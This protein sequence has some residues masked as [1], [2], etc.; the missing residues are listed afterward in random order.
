M[1]IS[2]M[3]I[4]ELETRLSEINKELDGEC[5]IAAL[6]AEVSA[7]EARKKEIAE[8]AKKA[9]ELRNQI[10][11]GEADIT[12]VKPVY[13]EERTMAEM[14][15]VEVRKSNEYRNAWLKNL[16][17]TRNGERLFGEM[18]EEERTAFTFLTSNTSA[19]VPTVIL[20][21]I[22][23][24]VASMAPMYDDAT[25]S[26]MTQGFAVP[27]LKS[28][29]Q[30]DAAVTDEAVANDDEQDTFDQLAIDGEEIKKH[31][32]M[33][34]KMKWQSIDAFEDWVVT[35]IAKRIAVAKEGAIISAL[36][37]VSTGI[38]AANVIA[39]TAGTTYSDANIRMILAKIK[40]MGVKVWYANSNTIYNGLAGIQDNNGRPLFL[41]NTTESD[42]AIAG[43]IYGG[44]VKEDDNLA[45]NVVYAGVPA[46]I[47]ANNFEELFI[48]QAIDPKTFESII[49]GYSLF[50][51]GLENPLAFVKVTFVIPEPEDEGGDGGVV[52]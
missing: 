34:R 33:S 49:G 23:E 41:A 47:L 21:R 15:F 8:E 7:I 43:R 18:N 22:V 39:A 51:A 29:A 3:N 42:P 12:D 17:V 11:N 52:V 35:H 5:D 27:R 1:K 10:A 36:D 38:A 24:L 44:I 26:G 30:G 4:E 2:E 16:A 20:N 50:G 19:V 25:K 45:D 9:E 32:V 31:I 37:T 48:N 40:E 28:I 46:S 14:N 13:K 6:E